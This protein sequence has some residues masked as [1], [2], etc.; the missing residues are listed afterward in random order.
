[1]EMPNMNEPIVNCEMPLIMW[2]LVQRHRNG[3]FVVNIDCRGDELR[4][5][6]VEG[7]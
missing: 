4:W 6:V 3:F 2:P 5:R 1:M 7:A